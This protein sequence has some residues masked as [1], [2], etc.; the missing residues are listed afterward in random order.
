MLKEEKEEEEKRDCIQKQTKE[1][2]RGEVVRDTL[3]TTR[4]L[5]YY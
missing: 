4:R 1:R 2:K 3:T 5:T